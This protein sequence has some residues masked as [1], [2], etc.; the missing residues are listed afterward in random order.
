MFWGG[1]SVPGRRGHPGEDGAS[2]EDSVSGKFRGRPGGGGGVLGSEIECSREEGRHGEEGSQ[3][4]GAS[5]EDRVFGG[6]EGILGG[7]GIPGSRAS[8]PGPLPSASPVT[9]QTGQALWRVCGNGGIRG[10]VGVQDAEVC[11]HVCGCVHACMCAGVG[12]GHVCCMSDMD[13]RVRCG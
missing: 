10:C 3:G 11:A 9:R 12:Y 13:L 4:C 5:R 1:Q 6:A 7:G 2:R 8:P